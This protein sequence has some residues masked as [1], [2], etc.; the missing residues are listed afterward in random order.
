MLPVLITFFNRP[1]S[2]DLVLAQVSKTKDIEIYFASDGPRN[3]QDHENL[4]A[5]W[6]LVE[7]YFPKLPASRKLVRQRNRGCRIAM[8]ENIAWFF[9]CVP[10]GVIL[11]DDCLPNDHFFSM[12][13]KFLSEQSYSKEFIS[14]SGTRVDIDTKTPSGCVAIPSI[15]PMVWGWGTWKESWDKYQPEITDSREIV[16]FVSRKL[17]PLREEWLKRKLFQDTFKSRFHEVNIGYI[18]TWDYALTAT[19]W[20]EDLKSL[21]LTANSI[22]NIGFNSAG[23]HTVQEAPKWVPKKYGKV[24]SG[25][26]AIG[27]WNRNL[28]ARMAMQVFNCNISDY[29]K[30]QIKRIL[31]H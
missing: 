20:R 21:Q 28:D 3:I 19:A 16:E 9:D 13:T 23:T 15:F 4:E 14:I 24:D 11:E 22:I 31:V 27:D 30:N 26:N 10:Y 8:I 2:L 29:S 5:C 7:K 1:A 6:G 17:F 25:V 12:Q 18:D